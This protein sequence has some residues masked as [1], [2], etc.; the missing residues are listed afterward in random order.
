MYGL[1]CSLYHPWS[2]DVANRHIVATKCH[3]TDTMQYYKLA[4]CCH[5][6]SYNLHHAVLQTGTLL[7]QHVIQ[8]APCSITNW[9]IVATACHTTCTMQ[10]Y[11]LA[12]CCHNMSYNLHHAVL[13]TGT[14]LPQHV[15]Q[16]APC[17]ITNWY[18]VAT[19][20][21]TTCTMQY[22]KLAHCCHNK[23]YNLHHAVLQTG[24]LLPQNVIQ[25]A[26]CSITNWY[27]V[28][29]TC[30]TTCTMQYYKLAHC[31]HNM[32]YNLHHAVLQTGTLLPQHVIQLAP[33]SI[34]NWH[35]VA[36]AC[37]TTC[38]KLYYSNML[39]AI[40]SELITLGKKATIHQVT[41]MLATSKNVPFPGHN[42]RCWWPFTL[43]ITLAGIQANITV[44]GHQHRWLAGGYH[45][46]IGH[47]KGG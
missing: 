4:H 1:T 30:H 15:I 35:T 25:L 7:P 12:H 41:T 14:L 6:T 39:C 26:P 11:K 31:C 47:F 43:I 32:S 18:I 19:T 33:C 46:E 34:T 42:H 36:T 9:Y 27:I 44:L 3:T 5:K 38:T 29:T 23:S 21:H 22:Y 20:C 8:L 13:Q 28:A 2:Y 37:H 10:Y 24:T 45:L 16:L 40:L 17:S